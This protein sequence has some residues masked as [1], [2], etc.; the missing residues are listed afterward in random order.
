MWAKYGPIAIELLKGTPEN[1]FPKI[2]FQDC[3]PSQKTVKIEPIIKKLRPGI[4]H[5]YSLLRH[6]TLLTMIDWTNNDGF[7]DLPFTSI[8]LEMPTTGDQYG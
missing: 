6:V 3:L 7:K 4:D 1:Y 2:T 8:Q 5:D